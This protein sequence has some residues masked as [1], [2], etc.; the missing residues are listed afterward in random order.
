MSPSRLDLGQS[1]LHMHFGTRVL[2]SSGLKITWHSRG[3]SHLYSWH[4]LHRPF[5]TTSRWSKLFSQADCSK[6]QRDGYSRPSEPILKQLNTSKNLFIVDS[7]RYFILEMD[8]QFVFID[9]HELT[10]NYCLL[11]Q[12][13]WRTRGWAV[14]TSWIAIK[15][16]FASSIRRAW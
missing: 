9:V 3:E 14:T 11:G 4:G 10:A 13:I 6:W 16:R 8:L 2:F 1:L 12:L 7:Q 5:D 15:G